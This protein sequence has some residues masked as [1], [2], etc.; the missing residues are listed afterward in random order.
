MNSIDF[1]GDGEVGEYGDGYTVWN[2]F[3]QRSTLPFQR[4]CRHIGTA[5][6][7]MEQT[8]I[9]VSAK[10]VTGG[11][12]NVSKKDIQVLM[13]SIKLGD[14]VVIGASTLPKRLTQ[15]NSCQTASKSS[16]SRVGR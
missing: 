6:Q 12:L 9:S 10:K 7:F 11:C 4:L 14:E 15:R 3:Q 1:K 2:Q 8:T 13:K 16:G 5:S